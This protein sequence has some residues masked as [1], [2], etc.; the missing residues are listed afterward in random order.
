MINHVLDAYRLNLMV[1]EILAKDLSA[2]QMCQQPHGLVN[3]PAW[4]LGHLVTAAHGLC[5]L[6]GIES[7]LPDGW[8]ETFKAGTPPDPDPTANPSK[9]ELLAQHRGYHD[10]ISQALPGLD[11]AT[12]ATPHPKEEMRPYFPTIGAQVV[13]MLTGHEMDHLGQIAAWRRAMGLRPAM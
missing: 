2:E 7:S 11:T 8:A 12:L 6:V 1:A 3:H 10:R 5:Q 4:S 9:D 13:F